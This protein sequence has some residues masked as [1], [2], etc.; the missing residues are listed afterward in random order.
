MN[1]NKASVLI[2]VMWVLIILSLL[3]IAVSYN[4]TGD[5]RIA[6]YEYDGIR[7]LYLAKAGVAKTIMELDKDINNYDSF[8]EDWNKEKKFTLGEGKAICKVYD[9]DARFNLNSSD[10]NEAQL[11][12][13]G[14]D[15]DLSKKLLAYKIKKGEKGFEFIEELFLI[16]GMTRDV[17]MKI[18]DCA[19]IYRGVDSKININTASE[20]ILKIVLGGNPLIAEKIISYRKGNDSKIGTEDDGIF[21]EENISVVFGDFGVTPDAISNFSSL[22]KARSGFFRILVNAYFSGNK[23]NSKLVTAIVD[24]SGKTYYW[25]ED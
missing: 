10:L 5:I 9:E 15:A 12:R 6:K 3:S 11:A 23:D 1:N 7:S 19:T 8:N 17:Y 4:A 2:F 22:F 18:K 13:L 16:D 25:K 24:K 14:L 20:G 21:T